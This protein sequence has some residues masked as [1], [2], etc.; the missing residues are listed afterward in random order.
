MLNSIQIT[1][2]FDFTRS[3]LI[4]SQFIPLLLVFES[5][6]FH[7]GEKKKKKAGRIIQKQYGKMSDVNHQVLSVRF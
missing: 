5:N 7:L 3:F 2:N 4:S 6:C 1:K